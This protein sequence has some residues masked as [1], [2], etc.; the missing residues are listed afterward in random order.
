MTQKYCDFCLHGGNHTADV[1]RL[2]LGLENEFADGIRR[3]GQDTRASRDV[4]W[5]ERAFRDQLRYLRSTIELAGPD[6]VNAAYHAL[7]LAFLARVWPWINENERASSSRDAIHAV[8]QKKQSSK[9]L[10]RKRCLS[11]AASIAKPLPEKIRRR[12]R[13]LHKDSPPSVRTI[14]RYLE[15]KS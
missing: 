7:Q 2:I 3:L 11:I 1:D 9:D 6:S 14:A 15:A 10:K 4:G 12:Y 13:E 8:N 5:Y